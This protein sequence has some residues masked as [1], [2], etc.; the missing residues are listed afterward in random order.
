MARKKKTELVDLVNELTDE[1]PIKHKDDERNDRDKSYYFSDF[2]L[3]TME[4]SLKSLLN[5]GDE[6]DKLTPVMIAELYNS[7]IVASR[8]KETFYFNG[9]GYEYE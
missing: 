1:K 2:I 4:K 5:E 3:E 8:A 6:L 9:E 7:S